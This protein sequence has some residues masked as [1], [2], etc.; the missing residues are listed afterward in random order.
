MIRI[1][2]MYGTRIVIQ[3]TEDRCNAIVAGG[4]RIISVNHVKERRNKDGTIN[5]S[6]ENPPCYSLLITWDDCK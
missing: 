5:P 1:E 6:S 3:K 2:E 4:G